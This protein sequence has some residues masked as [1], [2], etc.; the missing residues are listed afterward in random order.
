MDQLKN[1][2]Q[3]EL[4]CHRSVTNFMANL[5]CG[6]IAYAHQPRKPSLGREALAG[7]PA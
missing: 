3:I 5:M 7:L 4:S 1:I 2:S 6:L